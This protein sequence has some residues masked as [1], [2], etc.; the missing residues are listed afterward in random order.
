MLLLLLLLLLFAADKHALAFA[1][2]QKQ[3]VLKS[4]QH[5][6]QY[7][8]QQLPVI[9]VRCMNKGAEVNLWIGQ[10]CTVGVKLPAMVIACK[11]SIVD[12]SF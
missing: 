7:Q 11:S 9:T 2:R 5:Q 12:P 3:F 1:G 10:A 6:Y 4:G 8:H